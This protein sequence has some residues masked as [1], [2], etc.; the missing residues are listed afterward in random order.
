[1]NGKSKL[2]YVVS[3]KKSLKSLNATRKSCEMLRFNYNRAEGNSSKAKHSI[4]KNFCANGA[5]L[6][7]NP[8]EMM[9]KTSSIWR[10]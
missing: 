6:Y 4:L 3:S 10:Q 2:I 7:A 5:V 1:M 8:R 9:R